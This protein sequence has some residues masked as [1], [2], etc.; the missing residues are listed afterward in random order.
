MSLYRLHCG[1]CVQRWCF[2]CEWGYG[3]GSDED[4]EDLDNENRQNWVA[5]VEKLKVRK[6]DTLLPQQLD[7]AIGRGWSK[8]DKWENWE[9]LLQIIYSVTFH[10]PV[11]HSVNVAIK[12]LVIW[13]EDTHPGTEVDIQRLNYLTPILCIQVTLAKSHNFWGF[14]YKMTTLCLSWGYYEY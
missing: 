10:V 13:F 6:D 14:M 4:H 9:L 3:G 1:L 11:S 12:Q 7:I 2:C 5:T 8:E